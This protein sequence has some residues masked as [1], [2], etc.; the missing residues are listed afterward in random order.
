MIRA[1]T[2]PLAFF[3]VPFALY[4]CVM[5]AQLINPLLIDNWTRRVVVPLTLAGLLLA[6]GSL[7]LLGVMAPRHTGGYVPAHEENGRIVPGHME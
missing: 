6:A 4:A 1:L 5:L 7:V 2:E 3:L